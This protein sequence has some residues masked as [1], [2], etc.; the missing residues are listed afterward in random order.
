M[1]PNTYPDFEGGLVVGFFGQI[2]ALK[3]INVLTGVSSP[4]RP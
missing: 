3:G 4:N 2:S 1:K